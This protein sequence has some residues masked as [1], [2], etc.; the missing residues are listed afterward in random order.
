MSA[1]RSGPAPAATSRAV[2]RA[3]RRGTGSSQSASAPIAA[4]SELDQRVPR[5]AAPAPQWRQRPRGCA[6]SSRTGSGRRAGAWCRRPGSCERPTTCRASRPAR[7]APAC[8]R[9][10]RRRPRAGPPRIASAGIG[11]AGDPAAPVGTPATGRRGRA[12]PRR[13]DQRLRLRRPLAGCGSI[14]RIGAS[15][16]SQPR[17][18]A[19]A[20]ASA[21]PR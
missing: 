17:A 5:A 15:I 3:M 16:G 21:A 7:A 6:A 12:G 4:A 11:Q 10:C 1:D 20:A 13:R 14:G 19:T 8:R 2:P 9:S 18:A